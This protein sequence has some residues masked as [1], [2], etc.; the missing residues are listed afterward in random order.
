M[1]EGGYLPAILGEFA[2]SQPSLAIAA[3]QSDE[4][5]KTTSYVPLPLLVGAMLGLV[6]AFWQ[7]RPWRL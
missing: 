3:H 6:V 5:L 2:R 7:R 4:L 1:G